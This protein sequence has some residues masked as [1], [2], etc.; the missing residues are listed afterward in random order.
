[1]PKSFTGELFPGTPG[2]AT[3]AQPA[4]ATANTNTNFLVDLTQSGG[5]GFDLF[6]GNLIPGVKLNAALDTLE[7]L[8]KTRVLSSP[9]VVVADNKEARIQ[10]GKQIPYPVSSAEGSSVEF[11][12]AEL[13]LT[14]TPHVT[15]ENKIYMK[16]DTTKNDQGSSITFTGGANSTELPIITTKEAHTE[17]LVGNGDTTVLGGI[18]ESTV[19]DNNKAIPVLSK[20]P[21]LGYLFKSFADSKDASELMVFIT[22][23]IIETN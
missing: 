16:I 4:N 8:N 5:S 21:I 10:S 17:V 20:I 23:T 9:R 22:P 12:D 13:T 19:A 11:I 15:S 6:L 2:A 7:T 1:M 3:L 14:V 18:Y